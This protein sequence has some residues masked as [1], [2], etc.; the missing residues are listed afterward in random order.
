MIP[1]LA[2]IMKRSLGEVTAK[3]LQLHE[4]F[5]QQYASL[6]KKYVKWGFMPDKAYDK[7]AWEVEIDFDKICDME[8]RG[9]ANTLSPQTFV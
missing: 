8:K 7:V 3:F 2:G 6:V 9:L 5:E 1:E 4:I